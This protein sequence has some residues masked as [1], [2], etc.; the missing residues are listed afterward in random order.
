[1]K[2]I[3]YK[4]L[5]KYFKEK[6]EREFNSFY[7]GR[8]DDYLDDIKEEYNEKE[9]IYNCHV[10]LCKAGYPP[11]VIEFYKRYILDQNDN[12]IGEEFLIN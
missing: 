8:T 9:D 3:E 7:S 11:L 2:V 6:A 10:E 4:D 5:G 1:M 12:I